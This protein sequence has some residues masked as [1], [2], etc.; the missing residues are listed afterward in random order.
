MAMSSPPELET[1][2]R[3]CGQLARFPYHQLGLRRPC[4]SCGQGML[5]DVLA[6]TEL[7]DAGDHLT[8]R[9]F[10]HLLAY[11]PH[12][13]Q[14]APLLEGWFDCEVGSSL[15]GSVEVT[16]R[17]GERLTASALHDRI[18]LD[19]DLRASLRQVVDRLWRREPGA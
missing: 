12:R 5:L 13:A 16:T 17:A 9:E 8:L 15:G 2:C 7:P 6:G 18:Q 10:E 1:D 11:A 3:S 19:P 4:P 14:L